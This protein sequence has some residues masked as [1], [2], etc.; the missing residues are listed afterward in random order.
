MKKFILAAA[1]V[2]PLAIAAPAFA[3]GVGDASGS[4]GASAVTTYAP[5][6]AR[7]FAA[8]HVPAVTPRIDREA[9]PSSAF[10]SWN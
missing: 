5:V 4:F 3:Q 8:R 10:S 6:Q 2:A 9:V 7:E 1:L